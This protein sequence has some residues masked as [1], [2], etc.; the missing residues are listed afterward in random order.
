[1]GALSTPSAARPRVAPGAAASKPTSSLVG[2]RVQ[3]G[4]MT[5][6][7]QATDAMGIMADASRAVS[8]KF[9]VSQSDPG[10]A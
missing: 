1:M 7:T 8:R 2:P 3:I 5:I 6:H 4:S 10:L 9:L